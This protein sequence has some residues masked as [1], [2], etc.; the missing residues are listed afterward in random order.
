MLRVETRDRDASCV[1][2]EISSCQ[3]WDNAVAESFFH[4]FKI[5]AVYGE[6]FRTRE[7]ARR[8]IFDWLEGFYN[9]KRRHSTL[10][11][12]SPAEFEK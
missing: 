8:G 3:C 1:G 2:G 5:E 7:E 6:Q 11:Y 4:S 12:V 9:N 10:G